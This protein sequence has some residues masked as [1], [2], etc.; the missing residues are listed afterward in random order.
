M[1]WQAMSHVTHNKCTAFRAVRRDSGR[2]W[3]VIHIRMQLIHLC[4]TWFIYLCAWLTWRQKMT[5]AQ[6]PWRVANERKGIFRGETHLL[7]VCRIPWWV[8]DILQMNVTH[9]TV[10]SQCLWHAANEFPWRIAKEWDVLQMNETYCKWMRQCPWYT[11]NEFFRH[12]ADEWD[13]L[14]INVPAILHTSL[15]DMLQMN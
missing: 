15:L 11:A 2:H 12:I 14:Q 5:T 6:R 4:G 1:T 9:C 3:A 7:A 8:R 10:M 13:I